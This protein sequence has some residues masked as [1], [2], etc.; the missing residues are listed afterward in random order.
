MSH[1]KP[2]C[3]ID[4]LN[5]E[6]SIES[7]WQTKIKASKEL[8]HPSEALYRQL[9]ETPQHDFPPRVEDSA[10]A[11][12]VIDWSEEERAKDIVF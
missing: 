12:A 7:K 6:S 9:K 8:T 1:C 3:A 10:L 4:S 11:S 5:L 2:S